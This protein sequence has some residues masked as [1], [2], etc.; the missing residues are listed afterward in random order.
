[1]RE[2]KDFKE[3][4]GLLNKNNVNYLELLFQKDSLWPLLLCNSDCLAVEWG[5]FSRFVN[6]PTIF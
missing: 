5:H 2:E 1:M 3:F 6:M 4:I